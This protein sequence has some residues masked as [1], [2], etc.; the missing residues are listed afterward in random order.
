MDDLWLNV[1]NKNKKQIITKN[2]MYN[3]Y[4]SKK[5][6]TKK[7]DTIRTSHKKGVNI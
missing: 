3:C 4:S 1:Y 5:V 7:L 2:M 6:K